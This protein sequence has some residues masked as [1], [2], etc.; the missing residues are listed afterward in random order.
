MSYV[1]LND[2]S[3]FEKIIIENK[4]II[5]Y[6]TATWCGPCQRI[7]PHFNRLSSEY[8]NVKFVKIDVDHFPEICDTYKINSMPT[9]ILLTDNKVVSRFTGADIQNLNSLLENIKPE[10]DDESRHQDI[11]EKFKDLNIEFGTLL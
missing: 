3:E 7:F 6:F 8:T 10:D 5:L 11:Q 9:F 2:N 1:I 4:N